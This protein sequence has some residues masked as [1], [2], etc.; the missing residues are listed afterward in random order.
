MP[1]TTVE[2]L[3]KSMMS[4]SLAISF[5]FMLL[6]LLAAGSRPSGFTDGTGPIWL[7]NVGCRGTET[8]LVDCPANAFGVHNCVHSDDAGVSCTGSTCTEGDVR[9]QGTLSI[10]GR[11]EVC[12]NNVWGTVCRDQFDDVDAQVVCRQLRFPTE[13]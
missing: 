1:K 6:L 9:L 8:R 3:H 5:I 4:T 11:V 7:D 13:G 12:H 2:L 10:A